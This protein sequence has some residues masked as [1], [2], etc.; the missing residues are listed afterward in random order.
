MN[1]LEENYVHQNIILWVTATS[2]HGSALHINFHT[3]S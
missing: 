3:E 1:K 2:K